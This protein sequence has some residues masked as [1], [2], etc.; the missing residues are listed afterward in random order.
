M[1][2]KNSVAFF[3]ELKRSQTRRIFFKISLR[4]I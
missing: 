1:S 3:K 4:L 2:K